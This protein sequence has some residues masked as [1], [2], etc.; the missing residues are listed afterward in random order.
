LLLL[1]VVDALVSPGPLLRRADS[2]GERIGIV[3]LGDANYT[4]RYAFT[5]AAFQCYAA[6]HGYDLAVIRPDDAE[7]RD[8]CT[9]YPEFFFRKHCLVAAFLQRQAPGYRAF[10]MDLDVLVMRSDLPLDH[11]VSGATSTRSADLV[12]Y[13]RLWSPE[14]AAGNY[15]ARNTPFAVAFLQHW[16]A[17]AA[18]QPPGFSSADN[19]AL[20]LALLD[21]LGAP[22]QRCAALY[23]GL[24]ATN[25]QGAESLDGNSPYWAFVRCTK[26]VLHPPRAW[27]LPGRGQITLLPRGHAWVFDAFLEDD[28]IAPEATGSAP[29]FYH[30]VKNMTEA[31]AWFD[32]E[33]CEA[34]ADRAETP[35]LFTQRVANELGRQARRGDETFLVVTGALANCVKELSCEPL[36]SARALPVDFLSLVPVT[37]F[38]LT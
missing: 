18:R 24:H 13:E 31:A 17:Y 1:A 2:A 25:A 10:V 15:Q 32:L 22:R 29:V 23:Q 8:A 36:K 37:P 27:G 3:A 21:A 28:H 7:Y 20:H 11:W 34:R 33:R 6:R 30:G 9:E 16:A 12:F 35:R 4:R 26:A 19:G 14:V 38:Q 5:L